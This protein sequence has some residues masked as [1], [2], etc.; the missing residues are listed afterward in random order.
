[1]NAM[2]RLRLIF[3]DLDDTL[4]EYHGEAV[5]AVEREA[6]SLLTPFIPLPKIFESYGLVK[7]KED[8]EYLEGKM[9]M[10]EFYNIPCRFSRLLRLLSIDDERLSE[11]M[12]KIYWERCEEIIKPFPDTEFV[13]KELRK[14]YELGILTN[15]LTEQ[16]KKRVL[17]IGLGEYFNY[18]F[19]S[20][21][22]NA[23]KPSTEYFD[24]VLNA[25]KY[26][27][28]ECALVGDDPIKD[29]ESANNA[30]MVSIWYNRK[31]LQQKVNA[32]YT[33]SEFKEL[34]QIL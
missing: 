28:H 18:F 30:G 22:T 27:S 32:H 7:R 21:L 26:K 23:D 20:E 17:S 10:K 11:R 12:G 13:L 24:F 14:K 1:M 4:Y 3:F 6:L 2:S 25:I 15:G 9:P 19:T 29:I 8:E 33:I 16:Q 31:G 5:K 34:L